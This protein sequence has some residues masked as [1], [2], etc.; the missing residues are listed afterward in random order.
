[1]EIQIE[2]ADIIPE[3]Q[4]A[5]IGRPPEQEQEIEEKPKKRKEKEAPV[6]TWI[7][8]SIDVILYW[9]ASSI[10]R[11]KSFLNQIRLNDAEKDTINIS[12]SPLVDAVFKKFG[13]DVNLI[14][15]LMLMMSILAPRIMLMLHEKKKQEKKK[16]GENNEIK[17]TTSQ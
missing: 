2:D 14:S 13:L 1:M 17:P 7:A 11:K 15:S 9:T 16:V 6:Y 8:S 3:I 10:S 4:E 5:P 12:L